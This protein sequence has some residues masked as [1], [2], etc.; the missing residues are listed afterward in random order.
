MKTF[1]DSIWLHNHINDDDVFI[2]DCRFDLYDA[3]YGRKAYDER[4]IINAFYLDINEDFSGKKEAHGG[5]RPV[6]DFSILGK[7]L[8]E[9]GISMDSKIVLYDDMTYSAGRAWWQFKYMG[10]DEVYILD[11]GYKN[12]EK[13][14][15]PVTTNIPDKTQ[16]GKLEFESVDEIYCDIDY[17][18]GAIEDENVILIDSREKRRYTGEFE[19]LYPKRGHIPGALN[20]PWKKN[21]DDNGKIKNLDIIAENFRFIE[22]SQEVILHCGSGMA[23]AMNFVLLYELG[24]RIRLYVG[25]ISDW[26]SYEENEL[27]TGIKKQH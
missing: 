12:W 2:I 21:V 17:V 5:A 14:N 9:I 8:E 13:L 6:P 20:L 25:G 7:K 24:Y 4:H 27:E 16:N 10:F 23:G 26:I 15:F 1:V 19:P 18:K 11:G 3:S 22:C